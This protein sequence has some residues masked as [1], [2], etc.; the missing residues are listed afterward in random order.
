[1]G[2]DDIMSAVEFTFESEVTASSADAWGWITSLKGISAEMWPYLRMT[3]PPGAESIKDLEITPR[4]NAFSQQ[5]IFI[6][7]S[8]H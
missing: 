7:V 6:R 2:G 1:M 4:Q 3:V 5:N 8:P